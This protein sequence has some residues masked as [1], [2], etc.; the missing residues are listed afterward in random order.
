MR[1]PSARLTFCESTVADP[2]DFPPPPSSAELRAFWAQLSGHTQGRILE[3]NLTVYYGFIRELQ[4]GARHAEARKTYQR[5]YNAIHRVG[6]RKVSKRV[7]ES[8]Q[9]YRQWQ[10]DGIVGYASGHHVPSLAF[11]PLPSQYDNEIVRKL[12]TV[13]PMCSPSMIKGETELWTGLTMELER[14]QRTGGNWRLEWLEELQYEFELHLDSCRDAAISADSE[15]E[16]HTQRRLVAVFY[17]FMRLLSQGETVPDDASLDLALISQRR[18]HTASDTNSTVDVVVNLDQL[19]KFTGW[20]DYFS[21]NAVVHLLDWS[22][23]RPK[24]DAEIA[25]LSRLLAREYA[26]ATIQKMIEPPRARGSLRKA[27]DLIT[28]VYAEKLSEPRLAETEAEFGLRRAFYKS[29]VTR[30]KLTPLGPETEAECKQRLHNISDRIYTWVKYQSEERLS[31]PPPSLEDES[32]P[33]QRRLTAW[34]MYKRERGHLEGDFVHQSGVEM[35]TSL[36]RE[37]FQGLDPESLAYWESKAEEAY[38]PKKA[39]SE[40]SGGTPEESEKDAID[41]EAERIK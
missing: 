29:R 9:I 19:S 25:G 32:A 12:P 40:G 27:A 37:E 31:R 11:D 28:M 15:E 24:R 1:A 30:A 18:C 2:V 20:G 6:R 21:P 8:M 16:I 39:G 4:C 38:V 33:R 7:L 3:V 17:Q 35:W 10:L 22:Q 13:D 26:S 41:V 36:V 23:C 34:D 5:R 14:Q